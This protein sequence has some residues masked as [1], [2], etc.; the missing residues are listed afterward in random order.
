MKNRYLLLL[1]LLL[2]ITAVAQV[3]QGVSYQAVAFNGSGQ[4]VT[5][6]TVGVRVTILDNSATGTVVYSET[7]TKQTNAQGLFN[8]NIGQGA[9]TSG[10]FSA[11]AWGTNSKYLKV[12]VDPAGGTNYT[13][14][15]TNQLMSVPYALAA[16]SLASS[17]GGSTL[18][19]QIL[20]AQQSNFSFS[21]SYAKVVYVFNAAT[22]TWS[23]QTY[24]QGSSPT[25]TPCKGSFVFSDSYA[26]V[27]YI[28]NARSGG[29]SSQSYTQGS[30][31][32]LITD[33]LSGNY[34]FDDNN[35]KLLYVYNI[36][37]ATWSSQSYTQGSGVT[38]IASIGNFAFSDSYAKLVY[39]YNAAT[40]TWSSQ[41][42]TQ[43][44]SPTIGA[45]NGN[46]YFDDTYA[47]KLY[48]FNGKTGTWTSQIYTQGS[49]VSVVT[50]T[51]K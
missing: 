14:V 30:S 49:G 21:D 34:S 12:E 46:F 4:P 9:A 31:P 8:L 40:G 38:V 5:N 20:A 45:A 10:T 3:P 27:V 19:D 41:A 1:A 28:F 50:S 35:A 48:V 26:K 2:S 13:T 17:S 23:S 16:A 25:I 43:G 29:W 47:K 11:I 36:K 42:Y 37:T 15:G 18:S 44:S 33:T 24:T 39:V 22:G 7:H 32:T 6:A 51:I